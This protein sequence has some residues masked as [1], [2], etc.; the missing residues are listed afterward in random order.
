LCRV[1][2]RS[3]EKQGRKKEAVRFAVN[4]RE[5]EPEGKLTKFRTMEEVVKSRQDQGEH[6]A[7]STANR[8]FAP[9]PAFYISR[10]VPAI[11]ANL[12]HCFNGILRFQ[13]EKQR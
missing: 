11:H 3:E 7:L 2:A 9:L 8:Y 4:V 10:V 12:T 6:G 1:P 5:Q 13:V